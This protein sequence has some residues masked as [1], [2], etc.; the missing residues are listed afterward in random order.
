MNRSI[1]LTT[2]VGFVLFAG[3][4]D[5]LSPDPDYYPTTVGSTWRYEGE[6][7]FAQTDADTFATLVKRVEVTGT[8]TL[9]VGGTAA[10]TVSVD[11]MRQRLGIDTTIVTRDTTYILKRDEFVLCFSALDDTEPDTML[12]L[13]VTEGKTWNVWVDGAEKVEAMVLGREDAVVPAGTF[14]DCWKMKFTYTGPDPE[15]P[16]MH[17]WVA[18]GVGTVRHL[19]ELETP[20]YTS[21]INLRLTHHDVKD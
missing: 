7:L 17:Y 20:E 15:T 11:S 12:S 9:A 19:M 5:K 6:L 2:I 21:T 18:D 4:C 1:I 14:R 3:G 16:L 13:P 10:V 8:A